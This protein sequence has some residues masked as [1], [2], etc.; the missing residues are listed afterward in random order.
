MLDEAAQSKFKAALE[1]LQV[2]RTGIMGDV[3]SL[4]KELK[5]A[6]E[7]KNEKLS[8]SL[9]GQISEKLEELERLKSPE[10]PEGKGGFGRFGRIHGSDATSSL[11][12]NMWLIVLFLAIIGLVVLFALPSTS[13]AGQAR[14][15][16][17]NFFVLDLVQIVAGWITTVFE[18]I[19]AWFINTFVPCETGNTGVICQTLKYKSCEPFCISQVQSEP[20]WKG[21]EITQLA[22]V[23]SIIFDYQKFSILAE[24][25]NNG[26]GEAKFKAGDKELQ[27]TFGYYVGG[28]PLCLWNPFEF[29]VE[30]NNA[31]RC[32]KL[33]PISQ[34]QP[35]ATTIYSGDCAYTENV[36]GKDIS[37]LRQPCPLEPT[38]STQVRWVG[39]EVTSNVI[40]KGKTIRSD[41][42]ITVPYVFVV[43]NDLVGT[44][45]VQSLN[46]QITADTT[47]KKEG[48][49]IKKINKAYS[50]PGPL[51]MAMGTAERQVVSGVPSLFIIQFA[52]KGKG[53]VDYGDGTSVR[54][55]NVRIYLPKEFEVYNEDLELCD[56]KKWKSVSQLTPAENKTWNPGP[57]FGSH[58]I[59]EINR[60][61]PA[62]IQ[63]RTA[64]ETPTLYCVLKTPTVTNIET[65]D[66]KARVL[67]YGYVESKRTTISITGTSIDTSGGG[68]GGG[69]SGSNGTIKKSMPIC[70]LKD[71]F[72][73]C[74]DHQTLDLGGTYKIKKIIA[75]AKH[76]GSI[77][78]G[79]PISFNLLTSNKK[80]V[81]NIG[82][83]PNVASQQE[84]TVTKEFITPVS[85]RY[86]EA[87]VA[88]F[89][90]YIDT[91][92][93]EVTYVS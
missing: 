54:A 33:V 62:I 21:F 4:Q 71:D 84:G 19:L 6:E 81:G 18:T 74:D 76:G 47:L 31:D 3:E 25:V 66:F 56:F 29:I 48:Q 89:C 27:P 85:G 34:K 24:F 45:T 63:T 59:Y 11:G 68:S 39:F 52:N 12:G 37:K 88:G 41:I 38:D 50:P 57:G 16:F 22:V 78:T 28:D 51:M 61:I 82:V 53:I 9:R 23:P 42:T 72:G 7:I 35:K 55:E 20:A 73:L 70:E 2:K 80:F 30:P 75:K 90:P 14:D 87:S 44:L 69:G 65:F 15:Q 5:A 26:E 49:I 92:F 1:N 43:P 91:L 64:L 40:P 10:A 17:V 86:V 46:E 58:V 8:K 77:C 83:V 67:E 36:G 32:L 13:Q 79:D 93:A 60:D